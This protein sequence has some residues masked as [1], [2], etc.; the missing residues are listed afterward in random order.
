M[1]RL[2]AERRIELVTLA[3]EIGKVD[4]LNAAERFGVAVE[5]I[6][7]DL[8][9]LQRQGIMRRVH[10]G[11]ILVDRIQSEFSVEVRRSQNHEIKR[12]IAEI[13]ASYI[14][15][16]GSIIV[17]AGTTTELLA[18]FLRDKSELTVITNSLNLSLAI[19][20]SRTN[21]I[22]LGGRIREITLSSV[23]TH[24]LKMVSSLNASVSFIATNGIDSKVGFT[25]PDVDESEVKRVMIANTQET[26]V[27]ADH[28]KFSQVFTS[29]FASI[30][31][32]DRII[33]DVNAPMDQ[34]DALR[35][36]EVEV[37]LA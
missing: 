34:V 23:G 1:S 35:A 16:S 26:I 5:T 25:T 7:R 11:G 12:R 2:A 13:A 27:L 29:S 22:L 9:L 15:K 32:I 36:N 10:G 30:S 20:D 37:V 17:D 14:P 31:E 6:R 3:R 28:T 4:V 33:T 21:V 8:D 19:G 24:A 18:P